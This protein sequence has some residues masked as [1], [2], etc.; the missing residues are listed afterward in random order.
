LDCKG[1]KEPEIKEEISFIGRIVF[2]EPLA[3]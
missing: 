3:D 1:G 2:L